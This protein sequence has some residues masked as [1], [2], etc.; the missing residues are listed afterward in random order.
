[1]LNYN[2]LALDG[3]Q[4][5]KAACKN[6]Q[7]QSCCLSPST[8]LAVERLNPNTS[9]C[10]GNI[11]QKWASFLAKCIDVEGNKSRQSAQLQLRSVSL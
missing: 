5:H 11:R 7:K 4:N 2:N 9:Y 1:M 8:A 3:E 10:G 6:N